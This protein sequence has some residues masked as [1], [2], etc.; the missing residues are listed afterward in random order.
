MHSFQKSFF[1]QIEETKKKKKSS[2]FFAKWKFQFQQ[3][4]EWI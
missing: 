3:I 2:F 4:L 1:F